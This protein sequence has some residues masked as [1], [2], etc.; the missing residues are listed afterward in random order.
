MERTVPAPTTI[1]ETSFFIACIASK[2][3]SERNVTSIAE[4]PPFNMDKASGFANSTAGMLITGSIPAFAIICS[5]F[6]IS[7]PPGYNL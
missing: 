3:H 6:S 2:E 1:P 7:I 5:Q 4:I